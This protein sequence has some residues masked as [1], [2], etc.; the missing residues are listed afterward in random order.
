MQT[1]VTCAWTGESIAD[2]L[3]LR[4][5]EDVDDGEAR[6]EKRPDET[7]RSRCPLERGTGLGSKGVHS[8]SD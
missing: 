7:D 4:E 1:E 6:G 3:R 5:D 8:S 2:P